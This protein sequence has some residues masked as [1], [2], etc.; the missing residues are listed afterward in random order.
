MYIS[1]TESCLKISRSSLICANKELRIPYIPLEED[2]EKLRGTLSLTVCLKSTSARAINAQRCVRICCHITPLFIFKSLII[3]L[4][5]NARYASGPR[6]GNL[7]LNADRKCEKVA[8]P[9]GTT[10]TDMTW[11]SSILRKY[12]RSNA[13]KEYKSNTLHNARS[14][15]WTCIPL[16]KN[17]SWGWHPGAKTL[18]D[19]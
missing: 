19:S 4:A 2:D 5:I 14:A 1:F 10:V 16:F 7:K 6:H 18:G 8:D 3:Y 9:W 17:T 11:H 13:Y 12:S 15:C